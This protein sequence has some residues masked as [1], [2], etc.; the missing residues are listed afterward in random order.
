[1]NLNPFKAI[2]QHLTKRRV[3]SAMKDF[4]LLQ[5]TE[6][7]IEHSC[8]MVIKCLANKGVSEAKIKELIEKDNSLV[9]ETV[10]NLEAAFKSVEVTVEA[11][12]AKDTSIKHLA[13]KIEKSSPENAVSVDVLKPFK[14][15][16]GTVKNWF[17]TSPE[18]KAA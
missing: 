12:I 13:E 18:A 2:G 15:V 3:K 1:M 7:F 17:T 5:T 11:W 8:E 14:A 6:Q 10:H 16:G 4:K 9:V